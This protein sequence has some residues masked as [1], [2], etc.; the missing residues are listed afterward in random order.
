MS[1][2]D[3]SH[4]EVRWD[5]QTRYGETYFIEDTYDLFQEDSIVFNKLPP[6]AP[7]AD[8]MTTE[9]YSIMKKAILS[10]MYKV[11][12]NEYV[13]MEAIL[14]EFNDMITNHASGNSL[15]ADLLMI[16][17]SLFLSVRRNTMN[18][19]Q[20]QEE[21]KIRKEDWREY[22]KWRKDAIFFFFIFMTLFTKNVQNAV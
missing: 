17:A 16:F 5:F 10:G 6:K 20:K 1:N 12:F 8:K 22:M 14:L 3:W 11:F 9:K 18:K 2:Q 19:N 4:G 7:L 21:I 15:D 13:R